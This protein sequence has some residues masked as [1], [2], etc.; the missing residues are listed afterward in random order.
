M[1]M[2]HMAN[3]SPTDNDDKEISNSIRDGIDNL[4]R[5]PVKKSVLIAICLAGFFALYDVSNFQYISPV[6]KLDWH[7]TDTQIAYAIST[8]VLGQVIGAF[9]I[10]ICADFYG[11]KPAL[12]VSLIILATG[13]ILVAVS[14]NIFQVSIFRL[15]TGIG[16][17]AE[18]VI[19]A[20]YIGEMS[21]KSKRGRYT[22]LIFLIGTI[23]FAASGPISFVLLQQGK[24]MGIDGWRV[25]MGIPGVIALLLLPLRYGMSES[26]RWLLSKGRIKETS[27]L[28]VKLG[29]ST[30]IKNQVIDSTS[31]PQRKN[32]LRSFNNRKVL[33]RMSLFAGVWFLILAAG[34]AANLL[35]IEYVNQG[36]TISQSIAITTV[37]GIGY[38]IG[39]GLSI[40]LADKFERKYQFIIAAI[41][42]GFAFIL[43]GL[44][45]HDYIALGLASFIGFASN[46]WL[47]ASLFT[48]TAENFPTKIR[49]IASG[50][51]EGLGSALAAIGPVIFIL[52][53][54]FGFL[55]V[56][57]GL[58]SFLFVAAAI[59]ILLGNRSVGISLEQLNK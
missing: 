29:L 32:V 56:M 16:I 14:T 19:A 21:P 38:V 57:T 23:G 49:S 40:S 31:I 43:R 3:S 1:R 39:G 50:A 28:L 2:I 34:S 46:S 12:I 33:S 9:C 8:R 44:F 24:M 22:S 42:M 27:S 47:I 5:I 48:Y 20:A 41:I 25:L 10:T 6:L 18:V 4:G 26:P 7:L 45:V 55:S 36:Y 53:H 59:V 37:G 17:G 58:A 54:P 15:I 51:V 11:R 30:P 52:L 35:V 13:S